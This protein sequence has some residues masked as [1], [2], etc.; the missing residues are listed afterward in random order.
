MKHSRRYR[1]AEVHREPLRKYSVPEAVGIVKSNAKAKFDET[2]EVAANLGVDPRH[3]DQQVR[4]TV[5]LPHGTGRTVRVLVLAQG[6]KEKEAGAVAV[7]A[8]GGQD[9]GVMPL[10]AFSQRILQDI[11]AKA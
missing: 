9:L 10:D 6:D 5:V 4:G 2:V 1:E 11:A 7:R 3:A 8:R